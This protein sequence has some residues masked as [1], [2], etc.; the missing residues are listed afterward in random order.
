VRAVTAAGRRVVLVG[1]CM[2]GLLAMAASLLV[3]KQVTALALLAT[4][5]DFQAA[6]AEIGGHAMNLLTALEPVMAA[7][8]T[9]PVDVLQ[10]LF[11]LAEPHAVGD[12]YRAF[13]RMRQDSPRARRFV[14]LEDWLADGVPLSAPVARACIGGWYGCNDPARGAWSVGGQIVDPQRLGMPV[15]LAVPD[16]DRVVPP[17][18]AMALAALL[19]EA[20]VLRPAS[21]HIGMVAGERAESIL[22]APLADWMRRVA[23]SRR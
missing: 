21:G 20:T 9:V 15:L 3:P 12:K 14:V 4:P 23:R 7:S 10:C 1:Y 18:S 22:W 16:H 19:P 5:W 13:G 8:R 6:D 17:E 2:G 11:S